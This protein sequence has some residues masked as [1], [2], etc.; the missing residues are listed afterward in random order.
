MLLGSLFY[1][2]SWYV[3]PWLNTT[4][5]YLCIYNKLYYLI[6]PELFN[7]IFFFIVCYIFLTFR[8]LIYLLK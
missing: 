5:Y 3:Y 2:I 8:L 1:T 7:L 4:V 6:E